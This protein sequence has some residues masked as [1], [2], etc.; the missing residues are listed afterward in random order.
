MIDFDKIADEMMGK[1][2][3]GPMRDAEDQPKDEREIVAFVK[4]K[5]EESRQ[6]QARIS[7]EGIWMTN[8]AY[9]LGYDGVRYDTETR[10]Y[11]GSNMGSKAMFRRNKIYINKI[12]PI[13]QNRLARLCKVPP[14]YDVRPKSNDVED[15]DAARLALDIIGQIWDAQNID[16]KRQ[17]LM[18]WLQ[19]CGFSFGYVGWDDS[20]GEPMI[21]PMTGEVLGY[22]G[23]VK[24]EPVSSFEMYFDP[25]AK[26]MQEAAWVG[27]AKVRKLN[28]FRDRYGEKG[29]LVKEENAWLLGTDYELRIN[30]ITKNG[31]A[32]GQAQNQVKD[33]AIELCYYE[34]RSKKFPNGRMMIVANDV[35][36]EDKELPV[37]EIP[38]VKFDDIKIA[39]KFYSE[40]IITHM[41]PVQDYKNMVMRKR[42]EWTQ[43]LAAGK[44][45][46]AR[47]H[48]LMN[49]ALN[50]ES[51]EVVE[52]DPVA[53]ASPPTAMA[54]P[55]IPAYIYQEDDRADRELNSIAGIGE[56]SQGSLPSA[57]IPAVGMQFL[58]EQDETRLGVMV[59]QHEY[60]WAKVG[61]LILK[62]VA[63]YYKTPRLLKVAGDGLSYT[64]KHFVGADLKDNY[65]VIV[66]KGS[67][68]PGSKVL[69]RQE[70]LNAYSQGVLGQP[71]DPKLRQKVLEALEYGDIAE[72]Y[73]DQ[74]LDNAQIKEHLEGLE[75]EIPPP[76]NE[77]DNHVLHFEEKNRYRKTDKFKRLT[78]L[79]KQMLEDD[80]KYHL[81]EIVRMTNPQVPQALE[82]SQDM[83][84]Q[85]EQVD[86]EN[87]MD[88]EADIAEAITPSME[89][90]V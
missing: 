22:E 13:V 53:N 18:M 56:I 60:A 30:N 34:R 31:Q 85:A 68:I 78:D 76:R 43:R 27:R 41:R 2:Q 1:S 79:A 87:Q 11:V 63:K 82:Q 39:G 55:S 49:E 42:F 67:T 38:F 57:G 52:Y 17:E 46:A 3:K 58:Q 10:R 81:D 9:L 66:V 16:E 12:L 24:F 28:Y 21:D 61:Q 70:I 19:E 59:Q 8:I 51:G 83:M 4:S 77:N 90:E 40:S 20:L 6:T 62:Y 23:D 37:G 14:R 32:A 73:E 33:S 64:V 84:A 29:H 50:N 44:L 88:A 71:G 26:N 36:L 74:S 80:L 54:M 45:I 65:D 7:N 72:I 5:F 25:L 35:L 48:N 69:R 15:K 86:A 75:K 89:G 47:G